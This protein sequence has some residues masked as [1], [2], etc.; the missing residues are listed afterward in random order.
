MIVQGLRMGIAA[1]TLTWIAAGQAWADDPK[2]MVIALRGT[3]TGQMRQI[4]QTPQGSTMANCFDV[5]MV[6]VRRNEVI[7]MGTDCL[8]DI[9]PEA[10]GMSLTGTALFH[11]REGT[12]VTRGR[13]TVHPISATAMPSPSTHITGAIPVPGTNQVLSGTGRYHGKAGNVRLSGAVNLSRLASHNQI[14]F[15][16]L[17]VIDLN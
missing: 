17:F 6:D 11:F 12:L 14:T 9:V 13:T 4:P 16:C 8:S 1:I 7:G 10:G 3:A 15:D 2:T 5:Q